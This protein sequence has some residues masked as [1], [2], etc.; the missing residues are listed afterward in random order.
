MDGTIS[1][2]HSRQWTDID[3]QPQSSHATMKTT[4]LNNGIHGMRNRKHVSNLPLL[5]IGKENTHTHST[6]QNSIGHEQV[7]VEKCN[8][9]V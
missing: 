7:A 5:P 4:A 8:T 1:E 2:I 6:E 9:Y 3:K